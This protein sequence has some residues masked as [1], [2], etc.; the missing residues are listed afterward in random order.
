MNGRTIKTNIP[1]PIF[2]RLRVNEISQ[3]ADLFEESGNWDEVHST[4]HE[5]NISLTSKNDTARSYFSYM[6]GIITSWTDEK[7]KAFLVSLR[8]AI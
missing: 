7:L 3:I 6:K 4:Y 2:G 8:R 1:L 5:N